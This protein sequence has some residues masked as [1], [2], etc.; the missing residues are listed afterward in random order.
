MA[1]R[2]RPR[3]ALG[4]G[5]GGDARRPPGLRSIPVADSAPA[6][7]LASPV[8]APSGRARRAAGISGHREAAIGAQAVARRGPRPRGNRR[9]AGRRPDLA[10]PLAAQREEEALMRA[11][12]DRLP[13]RMRQAV[14]W[15]HHEGC[16]FDEIG[17][18][19]GCSDVAAR[20][21]WL[22]AM[23]RLQRE[24]SAEGSRSA[25]PAP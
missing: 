11:A 25:H 16:G 3:K 4:P 20:K 15:R 13:E 21:L 9:R 2:S 17:R 10:G 22:R 12:L 6:T 18:R 8:V 14:L 24:F 7:I 23:D 19:I 5:P 1:R